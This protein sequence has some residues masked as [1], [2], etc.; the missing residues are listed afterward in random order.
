MRNHPSNRVT[1]LNIDEVLAHH[2]PTPY[3]ALRHEA[4]RSATREFIMALLHNV[5]DSA[6]LDAAIRHARCALMTANAA[7]A[8]GPGSSADVASP[9]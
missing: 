3:R 8:L 6:D 2:P 4:V 7:I 1:T 5:P 9:T